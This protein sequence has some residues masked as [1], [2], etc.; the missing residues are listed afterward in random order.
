[1]LLERNTHTKLGWRA[2]RP[3]VWTAKATCASQPLGM[4]RLQRA[5]DIQG[6]GL[7]VSTRVRVALEEKT[8]CT[9]IENEQQLTGSISDR[10]IIILPRGRGRCY[11]GKCTNSAALNRTPRVNGHVKLV[12]RVLICPVSLGMQVISFPDMSAFTGVG[13]GEKHASI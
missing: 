4:S 2:P 10:V 1:M 7:V 11:K 3:Q 12:P 8:Q 9:L 13:F 6:S 5:E